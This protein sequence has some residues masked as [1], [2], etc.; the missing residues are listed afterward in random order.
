M[1]RAA[2]SFGVKVAKSKVTGSRG[3]RVTGRC[4]LT[5]SLVQLAAGSAFPSGSAS[6]ERLRGLKMLLQRRQRLLSEAAGSIVLLG[7][8]LEF[9]DVLLMVGDHHPRELAVKTRPGQLQHAVV[10]R[11]LLRVRL[12]WR[13]DADI[14]GHRHGFL[15]CVRMVPFQHLADRGHTV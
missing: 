8:L 11:L 14:L 2:K 15:I 5:I 9:A 3:A 1:A 12:V 7:F 4:G 13:G 6:R 10:L